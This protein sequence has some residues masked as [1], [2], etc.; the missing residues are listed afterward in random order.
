MLVK[1]PVE[2]RNAI[3]K[4]PYNKTVKKNAIK[5]YTALYLKSHLKNSVGYFPVSSEYLQSINTRYFN[6][7]KYFIDN[8]VIE[9]YKRAFEDPNDIF[10]T[11]YRKYYN[12]ERGICMKYRFLIDIEKGEDVEIDMV[13]NRT[14]RWYEIIQNS[15][16]YVGLPVSIKRDSYGRRVWHSGIRDYKFDFEGYYTIDAVCSQPRLLY[17]NIKNI[18]I[19]DKEYLDIFE[20]DKDF[21]R[22]VAYKLNLDSRDDAK[23]LF[24]H[25]LNGNGYVPNFNIHILFPVVSKY[26]K[27]IKKGNYK[28]SGSFLQ[29]IESKI[30]IDDILNNIPCEWALP[31]HDCVVIKENDADK[32]LEFCKSKYPDLRF[33][34]KMI[35]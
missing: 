14:N 7:I 32:V 4:M 34:K 3:N 28:N 11:E 23:E 15:L 25:W 1:F 12:T 31:I 5:I 22:E 21:Y 2:V 30:W 8:K 29:R 9:Y 10:N 27:D 13:T 17:L 33:E 18:G 16:E 6:I 24:M 20:N 26:L 19:V 35:K